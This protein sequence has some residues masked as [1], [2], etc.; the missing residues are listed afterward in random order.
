[1]QVTR[2]EPTFI[3]LGRK[4]FTHG[5]IPSAYCRFLKQGSHVAQPGL[6]LSIE[7]LKR[8]LERLVFV[9][10][11]SESWDDKYILRHFH[12]PYAFT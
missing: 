9:S 1:M 7:P 5:A 11:P 6:K 2:F 3:R 4:G 12:L 10:L 8:D